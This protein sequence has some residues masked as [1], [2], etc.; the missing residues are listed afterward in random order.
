M[1]QRLLL[2]NDVA[3]IDLQKRNTRLEIIYIEYIFCS[4]GYYE[5]KIIECFVFQ[6]HLGKKM[7]FETE[8]VVYDFRGEIQVFQGIICCI[9]SYCTSHV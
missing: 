6:F 2:L 3:V 9:K 8:I 7:I 4:C 5:L 1:D